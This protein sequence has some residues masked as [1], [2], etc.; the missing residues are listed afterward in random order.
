M[1]KR[2]LSAL[3]IVAVALLGSCGE[4]GSDPYAGWD[5]YE[6]AA[7]G[8]SVRYLS[9]PWTMCSGTEFEADC[10]ECPSQLLGAGVC[11]DGGA[12]AILWVPPAL[13]D[14]DFLLIPPYKLEVSWWGGASDP[15]TLA[16]NE[17]N[18]M[19][20]AGLTTSVP[21]RLV[22]LADGT[23]AAEVGYG[24]PMHIIVAET[25]VNRP[26][27]REFRVVYVSTASVTYRVAIDSGIDITS[28]EV[29]D[30][31]ASFTAGVTP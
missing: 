29:G 16:T 3:S 22:T 25:P 1:S 19:T 31:L 27:E 11:G 17:Q 23:V 24:G 6:S 14:P 4:N 8:F 9:P 30:M 5:L 13:L 21:A 26:D 18:V 12:N 20:A 7:G 28:P 10:H 15:L 2:V